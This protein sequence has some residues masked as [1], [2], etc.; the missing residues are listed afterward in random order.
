MLKKMSQKE[1]KKYLIEHEERPNEKKD[2][3]NKGEEKKK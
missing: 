3:D 1:E 2:Y